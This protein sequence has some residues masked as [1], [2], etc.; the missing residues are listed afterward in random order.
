MKNVYTLIIL[1]IT[2]TTLVQTIWDTAPY[3]F[4][5]KKPLTREVLS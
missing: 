4:Y 1:F 3:N 2:G 5:K